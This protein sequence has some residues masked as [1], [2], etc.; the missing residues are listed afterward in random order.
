[1]GVLDWCH[2]TFMVDLHGYRLAPRAAFFDIF[3]IF[4]TIKTLSTLYCSTTTH[5]NETEIGGG[6]IIFKEITFM[7]CPLFG[8]NNFMSTETSPFVRFYLLRFKIHKE[9]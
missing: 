9:F 5:W 2:Y 3:E 4:C 8:R 7:D 6:I 1:M